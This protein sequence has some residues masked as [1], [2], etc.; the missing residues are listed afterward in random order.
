MSLSSSTTATS[1]SSPAGLLPTPSFNHVITVKLTRS[2]YL[3]WK[4][5][6][7]PY[8]RSQQ[9]LGYVDGT[10]N[11]PPKTITQATTEGATQVSNPEYQIW[12]QQDQFVLSLLL[13]SLSV[14]VLS[15]VLFLTTSFDVWS[16]LERMFA[17]QSRAR[18]MQIRL[19]LSTTQKKELSVSDYFNKMK[20]LADTLA[21][22]SQPLQDEEVITYNLAG[23]D[24]EFDPL[25][26]S[27]TTRANQMSLNDLYAH[28]L[29]Y[30]MRMEHHN[31]SLHVG[32]PSA[33]SVARSNRGGRGRGRGGGRGGQQ[34]GNSTGGNQVQN[35][36]EGRPAC[37]VC[38][39]FGHTALK[40]YHRFNHSYQAEDGHVA[41]AATTNSYPLDPN[42]SYNRRPRQAEHQRKVL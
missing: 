32:G 30:E 33:N 24:S 9:L 3:L 28:L 17:S 21:A 42:W 22:I 18:I 20:N 27:I 12:L 39:K 15:Q 11:C 2:N 34:R 6:F 14:D 35:P 4:A 16:A 19:Q 37:Q 36:H 38:G 7:I 5:Q 10:I 31:S 23:L 8:L 26:T 13:S 1:N 41:A 29:T 25:V 40:C